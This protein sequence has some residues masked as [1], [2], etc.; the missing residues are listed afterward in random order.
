MP[1]A[2]TE[3][4]VPPVSRPELSQAVAS[5]VRLRNSN[6][7]EADAPSRRLG[8]VD[9][10]TRAEKLTS[11]RAAL[12][13]PEEAATA[14]IMELLPEQEKFLL[15][16]GNCLRETRPTSADLQR[17]PVFCNV[18]DG[19]Y[20]PHLRRMIEAGMVHIFDSGVGVIENG[21]FGVAKT[22]RVIWDGRRFNLYFDQRRAAVVLPSPYMLG[23][24]YLPAAESLFTS[25]SDIS[26][27]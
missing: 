14:D 18:E 6:H 25:T 5:F 17:L 1:R 27:M 12:P 19:H 2:G 7:I 22:Q 15:L 3:I 13:L 10:G 4:Y 26:Q 11:S 16:E 24:V 21:L 23:E 20:V 9:G 8:Y